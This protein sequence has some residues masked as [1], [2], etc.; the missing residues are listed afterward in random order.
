MNLTETIG[1]YAVGAIIG[2]ALATAIA[3]GTGWVVM[4]DSV[5]EKLERARIESYAAVCAHASL[6][7]WEVDGRR[8]RDLAGANNRDREELVE[9]F[10]PAMGPAALLRTAIRNACENIIRARA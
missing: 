8:I 1:H 3:F 5:D 10:I 9:R 7:S 4:A 6:T 2:I